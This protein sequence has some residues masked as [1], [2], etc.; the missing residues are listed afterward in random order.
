MKLLTGKFVIMDFIIR[1]SYSSFY[2]FIC[3]EYDKKVNLTWNNDESLV[4]YNR[5]R[6]Y[7][8]V[9]EKSIGDPRNYN[10]TVLNFPL[11]VS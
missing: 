11:L 8:F 6:Y 3:R 5:V 10:V 9:P 4:T 7:T 2:V 1:K